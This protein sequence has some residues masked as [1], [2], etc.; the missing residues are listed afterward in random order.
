MS[1]DGGL[2]QLLREHLV[3]ADWTAVETGATAGGVPDCN[4]CFPGGVEGWV[5]NKKTSGWTVRFRPAQVGWIARRVR[6]GGRVFV[7]VRRK[8]DQLI[9]VHGAHVEAVADR[10]LNGAPWAGA[11]EG[12]PDRW[13]WAEVEKVFTGRAK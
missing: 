5:E 7:A 13:D 10:G 1:S 6:H 9:I 11:W 2:R 4:F 3:S 8:G 12:G